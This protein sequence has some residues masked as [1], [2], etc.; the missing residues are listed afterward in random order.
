MRRAGP[1]KAHAWFG[2]F[3]NAQSPHHPQQHL[4]Q[5]T[6]SE[7][8]QLQV[9][10]RALDHHSQAPQPGSQ[11]QV[12]EEGPAAMAACPQAGRRPG[13]VLPEWSHITTLHV[14]S[15]PSSRPFLPSSLA[16]LLFHHAVLTLGCEKSCFPTGP[17]LGL[18]QST[19]LA[20]GSAGEILHTLS[21][22][23][24]VTSPGFCH[25]GPMKP[26]PAVRSAPEWEIGNPRQGSDG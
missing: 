14:L 2:D 20:P 17:L 3:A 24:L 18:N 11:P 26:R 9:L 23:L 6:R 19:V 10:N 7:H 22:P 1:G 15:L 21:P 12:P 13:P 25:S 4:S 5:L 8:L 16:L